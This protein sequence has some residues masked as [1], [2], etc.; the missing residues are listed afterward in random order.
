MHIKGHNQPLHYV[1]VWSCIHHRTDHHKRAWVPRTAVCRSE[2]CRLETTRYIL[3]F[4][5]WLGSRTCDSH[6]EDS[7]PKTLTTYPAYTFS[8]NLPI[9]LMF[10]NEF[11]V[12]A[13]DTER[14]LCKNSTLLELLCL[15]T[16][17]AQSDNFWDCSTDKRTNQPTNQHGENKTCAYL[18]G[19]AN[20]N[21][22]GGK[23][24]ESFARIK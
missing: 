8:Y 6:A 22:Q 23:C 2:D 15:E 7:C 14:Y 10:S 5:W 21:W 4:Q 1:L 16:Q 24:K 9:E 20:M 3:R 13:M 11:T 17:C 18:F 12:A 19:W